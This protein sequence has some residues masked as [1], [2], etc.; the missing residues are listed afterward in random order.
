VLLN[1]IAEKFSLCK[2]MDE[3]AEAVQDIKDM[4]SK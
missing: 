3:V 4:I 2:N 1:L